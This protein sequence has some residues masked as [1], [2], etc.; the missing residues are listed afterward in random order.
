MHPECPDQQEGSLLPHHHLNETQEATGKTLDSQNDHLMRDPSPKS[1]EVCTVHLLVP[2]APD[3]LHQGLLTKLKGIGGLAPNS[4]HLF[5]SFD[6]SLL[7]GVYLLRKA[8]NS[9]EE[10]TSKY[11]DPR[12]VDFSSWS[13]IL[14]VYCSALVSARRREDACALIVACMSAQIY[15]P[16]FSANFS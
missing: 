6:H 9:C 13:L 2:S 1:L 5:P 11:S 4:A 12:A 8:G 14:F 3:T 16:L 10:L 7:E 15:L